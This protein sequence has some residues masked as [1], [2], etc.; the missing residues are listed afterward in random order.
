MPD[1]EGS[2]VLY[3]RA[4][5][6]IDRVDYS[7]SMH[8]LF[9]SGIAGIALEKVSPELPSAVKGN[10]H[11]ASETCGWGT[12]G[13][14]NSVLLNSAGSKTGMALS[15]QRVS[16]DGDGFED[17]LSVDIYPGGEDN[18]ITVTVFNDRGFVVRKV[19]ERF[20]A[21]AGARFV[22]DGTAESGARLPA[23][24]YMIIAES[25]NSSGETRRWRETCALL[26]R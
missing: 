15:A 26:Y 19:A 4:M 20:S 23:G 22:W 9:L 1:D 21:G 18:I 16:P 24:L 25:F 3:D 17:V 11:S 8:L 7:S 2:L 5:K 10:W 12:P 13:A 14:E 6:I